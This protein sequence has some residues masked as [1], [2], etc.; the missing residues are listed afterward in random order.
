MGEREIPSPFV[1]IATAAMYRKGLLPA[2]A[3]STRKRLTEDEIMRGK[4]HI[5]KVHLLSSV[6][7]TNLT[8]LSTRIAN[9]LE[10]SYSTVVHMGK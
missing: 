1:A 6:S 5:E 4:I 3:H 8:P 10:K 9:C 7:N 2:L